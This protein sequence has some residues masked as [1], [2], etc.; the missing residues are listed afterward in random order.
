MVMTR[1]T[2]VYLLI[3]VCQ[4]VPET[5]FGILKIGCLLFVLCSTFPL[6]FVVPTRGSLGKHRVK[7][8]Y[9]LSYSDSTYEMLLDMLL[10]LLSQG[11]I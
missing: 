8:V 9:I 1:Y 3:L 11:V 6:R 2:L 5:V 7:F 10:L 4:Y